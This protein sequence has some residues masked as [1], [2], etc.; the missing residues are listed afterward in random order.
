[1]VPRVM[2][3]RV[4]TEKPCSLSQWSLLSSAAGRDGRNHLNIH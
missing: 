2:T 4:V 3:R 1:M